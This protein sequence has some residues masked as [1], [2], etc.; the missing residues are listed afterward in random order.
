MYFHSLLLLAVVSTDIAMFQTSL[1]LR[2]T[3][4]QGTRT[5]KVRF[6]SSFTGNLKVNEKLLTRA[7]AQSF[8][9]SAPI[10]KRQ[11]H[12]SLITPAYPGLPDSAVLSAT[13][14]RATRSSQTPSAQVIKDLAYSHTRFFLLENVPLATGNLFQQVTQRL[15]SKARKISQTAFVIFHATVCALLEVLQHAR[16][17][18]NV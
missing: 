13:T 15:A 12:P 17:Q 2:F 14:L 5:T 4:R 6:S 1:A 10:R 7:C 18:K 11:L 8:Y 3:L 9:Q 16:P